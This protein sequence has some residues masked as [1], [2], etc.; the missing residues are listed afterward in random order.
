MGLDL[1]VSRFLRGAVVPPAI[2]TATW[3]GAFSI[4]QLGR[5]MPDLRHRLSA[6]EVFSEVFDQYHRTQALGGNDLE[7]TLAFFQRFYMVDDIL[8]KVDRASMLH[9]LEVRSPFLDTELVR[10]TQS[11]PSSLKYHRGRTKHIL[12]QAL[13]EDA[14]S[15]PLLPERIV[16]RKKKG[17]GI[18]TARWIRQELRET[19]RQ[20]LIEDWRAESL[21]MIDRREVRNLWEA[22]VSR[23]ENH[24]KELWALSILA[25]WTRQREGSDSRVLPTHPAASHA[26]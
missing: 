1:K 3:M 6:E 7:Q 11:L 13:L 24:A 10:F 25:M 14:G 22:H 19:F 16:H 20:L 18:P 9:S 21:P 4:E 12:K 5:L 15:G 17:F 26:G 8:V 2:R 23:R